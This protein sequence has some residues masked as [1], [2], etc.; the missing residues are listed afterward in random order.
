[1]E[2]FEP[3]RAAA[4]IIRNHH[5]AWNDGK[6]ARFE[7]RNVLLSSHILHLADRIAVFIDGS[8][9]VIGQIQEIRDKID[10]GSGVLFRPDLV[11]AFQD[12]SGHEYIWLDTT[13]EPL[14]TLMPS[15]MNFDT[16]ELS[17]DEVINLSEIF[18]NIIDFRSPFTSR[19]SCGVASVAGRLAEIVGVFGK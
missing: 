9:N 18:A 19:H 12:I 13:Y 5:V 14:M 8:R 6:G 7:G 1:M 11:E 2:H 3:L 10:E 4:D 17:L 15:M 16:V